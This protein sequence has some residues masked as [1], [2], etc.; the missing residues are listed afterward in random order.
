MKVIKKVWIVL[1]ICVMIQT[2][3][4]ADT[5]DYHRTT[6]GQSTL[7]YFH[8]IQNSDGGF[9]SN[10]GRSSSVETTC[11]VIMAIEASGQN[12]RS[13]QWEKEGKSP[14]DYLLNVG[15][16][17]ETTNDYSRLLLTLSAVDLGTSYKGEDLLVKIKS[18]QQNDGAFYQKSLQEEGMV[19]GHMWAILAITSTGNA[20][21]QNE[22]AKSWLLGQQNNDGGFPWLVGNESDADDTAIALQVL[23]ILGE[24]K[25]KSQAMAN[26]LKF[27]ATYQNSDGGFE[28]SVMMGEDSNTASSA[29]VYQGLT[30]LGIDGSLGEWRRNGNTVVDYIKDAQLTDGSFEWKS[31]VTASPVKMSAY[32]LS[33]LS[34]RP[35]P[36]NVDYSTFKSTI[37]FSDI[38]TAHW[39]YDAVMT[40]VDQGALSGYPD[41][42]FKPEKSVTRTEFTSMLIKARGLEGSYNKTLVF[43]D[44]PKGYWG[45]KFIGL[46]YEN[47]FI[48]GRSPF[49]FDPYGTITGAELA[50]IAVNTM[51]PSL[52][53]TMT[54]GQYWYSGAVALAESEGLLYKGFVATKPATRAECA[55]LIEQLGQ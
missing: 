45:Y 6:I 35:Y 13:I 32:A 16:K 51:D 23:H 37:V 36:V 38:S 55:Y 28:A 12:A 20:I 7:N 48:N 34:Q 2:T 22:K 11:W 29:W 42:S 52:A 19:N 10:P 5:S 31:A 33:A 41:G 40:L 27:M 43:E 54:S 15:Y 50:T 24:N 44:V 17:P 3:I 39:A 14:V 30:A 8:S 1:L 21:P 4:A 9:P 18:F 26:A 47:G 25:E 49:T 53:N 46:A